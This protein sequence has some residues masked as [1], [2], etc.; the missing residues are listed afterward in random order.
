M[1]KIVFISVAIFLIATTATKAQEQ[2]TLTMPR[3]RLGVEAGIDVLFGTINKPAQIRESR[4]YYFD[5]DYDYNCGFVSS[6]YDLNAFYFGIKPEYSLSKRF[7]ITSG[8]RFSTY[9]TAIISD[10]DYFLW[11]ISEDAI[12]TNYVKIESISQRNY[13]IGIPLE[14]RFFPNEKDYIARFYVVLGTVLN[15]VVSSN[16]EVVFPNPLMEKYSSDVLSQIEKPNSFHGIAYAGLGLKIGKMEHPFGRVEVHMPSLWYGNKDSKT[17]MNA[18]TVGF[19]LQM[20]VLIPVA[21]KY[22]LTYTITD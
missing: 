7:V 19:G 11:K 9:K 17:F 18:E 1:K 4:S 3:L 5:G 8:L 6:G 16:N 13:C 10:R 2:Q 21:K 20:T 15:F 12:N 22:Q 14:I